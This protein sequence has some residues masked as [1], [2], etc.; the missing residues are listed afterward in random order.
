M[1]DIFRTVVAVLIGGGILWRIISGMLK[2]GRPSQP[3]A[4]SS[5]DPYEDIRRRVEQ[6]RLEMEEARRQAAFE[7]PEPGDSYADALD[8]AARADAAADLPW[9]VPEPTDEAPAEGPDPWDAPVVTAR[10][11]EAPVEGPGSGY[12]P[13]RATGTDEAP[14]AAPSISA[15]PRPGSS[16]A[17]RAGR[18]HGARSVAAS[19]LSRGNL[20]RALLAHEILQPPLSL[21]PPRDEQG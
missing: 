14:R 16:G 17:G 12:T 9:G 1:D 3:Q 5:D 20:R 10:T 4:P 7:R 6:R 19:A 11:D 15:T 2:A 18:P 8:R 13:I 21:R